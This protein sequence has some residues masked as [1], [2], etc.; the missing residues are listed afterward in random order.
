MAAKEDPVVENEEE[1]IAT[2]LRRMRSGE[3]RKGIPR[4]KVHLLIEKIDEEIAKTGEITRSRAV[5][6]LRQI[7]NGEL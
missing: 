3:P 7:K 6:L 2:A 5:A 4:E 1:I